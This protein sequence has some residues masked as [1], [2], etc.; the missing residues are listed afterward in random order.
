MIRK[1]EAGQVRPSPL[2][3]ARLTTC[4][5]PPP[6]PERSGGAPPFGEWLR[7]QRK[8]LD[9]TQDELAGLAGCSR[10]AIKRLEQGRLRPSKELAKTLAQIL[11]IPLRD[12]RV[13]IRQARTPE[14][15]PATAPLPGAPRTNLPALVLPL[16]GRTSEMT[17]IDALLRQENVRIVTLTGPPGIGKTRLALH[18]AAWLHESFMD[19]VWFVALAALTDPA[20]LETTISRALDLHEGAGPPGTTLLRPYLRHKHLLLVLDNF[21]HL[22]AAR[23]VL[24]NLLAGAPWVKILVTSRVVLHLDGEHEVPIPAL[25]VP[26][27]QPLPALPRLPEYAAVQL[28]LQRARAANPAFHLTAEN[29]ATVA[30]IC[31][32]LEGVPLALEL[33]A[34][35][36][37][38]LPPD[39]VRVGLAQPLTLLATESPDVPA[40]HQAL[41]NALTWSYELLQPEDQ[42]LFASLGVFMGGAPLSLVRP[43]LPPL[44]STT[45]APLT[46]SEEGVESGLERLLAH[47]LIRRDE[48]AT[49]EPRFQMLETVRAYARERLQTLGGLPQAQQAH[50][51]AYLAL[52]EQAR[53]AGSAEA[54]EVWLARLEQEQANFGA[55]LEWALA[56]NGALATAGRLAVALGWFWEMRGYWQE[57]RHW[58]TAILAQTGSLPM[59]LRVRLQYYA[60]RFAYLQSDYPAAEHLLQ[61][62]LAVSQAEADVQTPLWALNALG[63]I[64]YSQ[65]DYPRA[66][67]F[68]QRSLALSRAAEDPLAMATALSHLGSIAAG[69]GDFASAE[70]QLRESLVLRQ[71][72]GDRQGVV[73]SLNALGLVVQNREDYAQARQCFTDSLVLARTLGDKLQI[74]LTLNNLGWLCVAEGQPEQAQPWLAEAL[75]VAREVGSDWSMALALCYLGWVAYQRGTPAQAAPL[76]HESLQL[77]EEQGLQ[78]VVVLCRI[79]LAQVALA[80][81]DVAQAEQQLQGAEDLR[82]RI[83]VLLTPFEQ[84]VF[85][86]LQQAVRE[87]RDSMVRE[88]RVLQSSGELQPDGSIEAC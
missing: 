33:A 71:T 59:P 10:S 78:Q 23:P 1:L 5:V 77:A 46:V 57:A 15:A 66:R 27:R 53:E 82:Q 14:L 68:Y 79:G 75:G 21:E 65:C 16:L 70:Q 88:P 64:A 67:G 3:A 80:A 25:A 54:Q 49:Q 73:R 6:G 9:L 2:L 13:W 29:A 24:T 58:F 48:G 26:P 22:L 55:V 69:I 61:A 17:R 45:P 63:R 62:S 7:R 72:H 81:H 44:G 38:L 11:D 87:Q 36:S 51:S 43:L 74:S 60:G 50:A 34:A 18:T 19:G 76:L 12:Q 39:R 84:R 32:Q 35:R 47:N 85:A 40:R 28:F 31:A 30:E 83:G 42:M 56:E 8:A 37:R 52:A 20:L 41:R 4:L 86:R